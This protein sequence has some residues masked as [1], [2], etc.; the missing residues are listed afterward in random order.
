MRIGNGFSIIELLVYSAASF[1]L[2]VIMMQFLSRTAQ[3]ILARSGESLYLASVYAGMDSM[4]RDCICSPAD[5]KLWINEQPDKIMWQHGQGVLGFIFEHN[6]LLRV[7]RSRDIHGQLRS[8][9]YSPL[10]HNVQ[11]SFTINK[12]RGYFSIIT[13]S[14]TV[15]YGD[16]YWLMN[17]RIGLFNGVV[18]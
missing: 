4:V 5:P 8:P 12:S 1:F 9:T 3:F 18:L 13:I 10:I 14:L 16:R 17:K 6:K 11:G 15:H 2:V 7:S